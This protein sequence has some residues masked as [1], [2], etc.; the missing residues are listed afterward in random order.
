MNLMGMLAMPVVRACC[1][2]RARAFRLALTNVAAAQRLTLESILSASTGTDYGRRLAISPRHGI[3]AFRTRV[4]IVDYAAVAPWIEQQRAEHRPFITPGRTRCYEPT[5][6]S[7]GTLKLIPYNDALLRSFRSLFAIWAHDLL[8]YRLQPRSGRV[9]MSISPRI[10]TTSG[11][12]DDQEYLGEPLRTLISRFLVRP[13][14]FE[15]LRDA[16][17]FRDALACAL[18]ACEDLEVISIWNPGYL[19]VLLEHAES[20]R[21]QLLPRLPRQR[22]AILEQ[23]PWSWCAVWPRLQLISCWTANTAAAPSRRLAA[24]FPHATMQG[25]GLLATEAPITVPLTGA[26]GALPLVDEVFLELENNR[27]DLHLLHEAEQGEEYAVIVTQAGGLLRYRLGDR[28]RVSDKYCGCPMLEFVGRVDAVS[29]L[30]GEKLS[31]PFV[32]QVAHAITRAGTFF[33]LL[34]LLPEA[35][36][37]HYCLLTDDPSQEIG[38]LLEIKLSRAFRYHEARLL[39]QLEAV[40]VIAR[41]DMRRAVYDAMAACGMKMGDIKDTVLVTKQELAGR[42][43]NWLIAAQRALK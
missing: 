21:E 16:E 5:S 9:F 20:R 18:L 12:D 38:A 26:K 27:G 32:A 31:E 25:K 22:R 4:P 6:G 39:G 30:V 42:I 23:L 3:E 41:A 14:D 8:K 36:R 24:L 35:G 40:K 15:Q 33:T 10:S 7:G 1:A 2:P 28:V 34:P 13:P 19:L 29:D 43:Y 37:P 11:F 17:E